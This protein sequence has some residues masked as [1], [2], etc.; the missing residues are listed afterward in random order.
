MPNRFIPQRTPT[1]TDRSGVIKSSRSPA[2]K[3]A[4]VS[5]DVASDPRLLAQAMREI[6]DRVQALER[7]K[8]NEYKEFELDCQTSG[9][10]ACPHLF[11]SPVRYSVVHWKSSTGTVAPILTVNESK[12]DLNTL[13]LNS[14]V[15]GRAVVRVE[16]AQTQP[17][18]GT[19]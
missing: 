5:E 11:N 2:G 19:P 12:T 9:T 3:S 16:R 18:T 8:P 7:V 10:V 6:H 1:F 13:T 15:K 4:L 17:T 14:A